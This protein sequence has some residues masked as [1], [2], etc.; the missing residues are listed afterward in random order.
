M[1]K[2]LVFLVVGLFLFAPFLTYS[3]GSGTLDAA[4]PQTRSSTAKALLSPLR[5][6]ANEDGR[7][8][9]SDVVYIINVMDHSVS[10]FPDFNITG[11]LNCNLLAGE[12]ADLV[13][14][15]NYLFRH[16]PAPLC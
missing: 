16:G 7:V 3:A 6:D 2:G 13:Y 14:L 12:I 8:S 10:P 11:D 1:K 9:V 4:N 15:V 5:G